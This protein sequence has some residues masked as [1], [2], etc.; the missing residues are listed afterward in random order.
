MPHNVHSEGQNW[1]SVTNYLTVY[2]H[3]YFNERTLHNRTVYMR[4]EEQLE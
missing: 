4:T 3:D 2:E 1:I